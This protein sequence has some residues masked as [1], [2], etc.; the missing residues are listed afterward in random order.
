M[1]TSE[2]ILVE[3]F[4]PQSEE[5]EPALYALKHGRQ[6]KP[7]FN[8]GSCFVTK[9]HTRYAEKNG[10]PKPCVDERKPWQ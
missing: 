4:L 6:P 7:P 8:N 1:R 9:R 3:E 10:C 2:N 5:F